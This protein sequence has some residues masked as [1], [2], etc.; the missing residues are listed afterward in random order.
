MRYYLIDEGR[1]TD[2]ELG[3]RQTP[4]SGVFSVENAGESWEAL[5]EAVDRVVA[6]IQADPNKER[7]DRIITRWLKR[8][9]H[10]LGARVNLDQLES[11]VE[12]K[13]M[14]AENLENLV[15]KERL[16]GRQEGRQEGRLAEARDVVRAQLNFK[17]GE[18]PGW[19]EERLTQAD[20]DQLKDWMRDVLFATSLEE[21]FKH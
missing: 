5:Q 20:H 8:H 10:R 6:I 2:E 19:V 4:L 18:V 3:L 14:L 17:F 9:L 16:E 7:I 11:L 13:D 15:K 21:M 12:D 1:Y